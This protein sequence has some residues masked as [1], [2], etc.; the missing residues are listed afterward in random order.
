MLHSR[1]EHRR[2]QDPNAAVVLYLNKEKTRQT[3]NSDTEFLNTEAQDQHR[4]TSRTHKHCNKTQGLNTE[5]NK[6]NKITRGCGQLE[7]PG[8]TNKLEKLQRTTK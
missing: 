5:T 6:L 1:L 8:D 4:T 2:N 7:T 3:Q